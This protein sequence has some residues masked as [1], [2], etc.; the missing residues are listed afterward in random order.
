MASGVSKADGMLLFDSSSITKA[1][2]MGV[3]M[4]N[5]IVKFTAFIG[6]VSDRNIQRWSWTLLFMA[7]NG[8]VGLPIATS[9]TTSSRNLT[10][11]W[12]EK[13]AA[14]LVENRVV[15]G[16]SVGYLEGEHWG[17]VHLGIANRSKKKANNLTVYEVGSISKVFTSLL[18]ADAVVR[19]EIDLNAAADVANPAEIRLPSRNGHSINWIDLST[20]RSGLPP[21]PDN[22]PLTNLKNPY[23][24]YGSK[25][26][27]A[28]LKQYELPRQPGASREYSN[29]GV[30]VL[31]YL[32]AS[33]TGKSYQQLLLER[34]AKPLRMADCTVALSSDQRRRLATPHDKFGSPTALWTFA[35]L[36]GAGGVHA[37]MRDM[38]RFAKAQLTPP[39]GTLGEAIE[40]AWKQHRD[41]DASGPAMGLGWVI[42]PDGQTR[43]HNGGT[44]GFQSAL[45]INREFNCAVVVLCN[46][47]VNNEVDL[48]AMELIRKAAGLET[49]AQPVVRGKREDAPPKLSPFTA[50]RFKDKQVIVAYEGKTYQWLELNGIK[51]EGIITSSKK[52]FGGQ[53]KKRISEDLVEL[54]W[55][56]DHKPGSKVK[57]RLLDLKTKRD[58]VVESASMT[59]ENRNAI[60]G[61]RGQADE[62]GDF[63][64]DA[65]FRGRLV[66]RYQLA[67][68]F[69]FTVRDRDGHLMVDVTNQPTQEVFPDSPTRWS[70]PQID[71]TLEFKLS[72][73]GP[74]T[75]L[76]L[77]QNGAKQTA[78][79]IEDEAPDADPGD[80]AIDAELRRRLVGRYQLR[81]NFIFTVRDRDGHLMVGITNQATQEVYPDSPTRWSYRG[82]DATLE[83]KLPKNGSAKS[84]VLHQNGA[85]Q[86]ARRMK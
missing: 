12:V 17:I 84:L 2:A 76:I 73:K 19:G 46:T 21:L 57:L 62:A 32:V 59:K 48:L 23:R 41:A 16:L 9:Q 58:F 67:P 86:I 6:K 71:A 56:M 22:L 66:G 1:E 4:N 35:D 18:L 33:K 55:G 68:K 30:S 50:V 78:R 38:M 45:Y 24:A 79:R 51:V 53:W 36:P 43:W 44:G 82:L 27:A 60:V 7:V 49:K 81:P 47:N 8:W 72:K 52:Q 25:K 10:D 77:H 34:I 37:T 14:P 42:Y 13:V 31:G 64:I 70:C 83:F 26:A 69:I 40:L 3:T 28:F 63:T 54:L 80:L 75:S 11:A 74:A 65:E 20:H 85:K 15:D 29:F 61:D 39:S 5:A